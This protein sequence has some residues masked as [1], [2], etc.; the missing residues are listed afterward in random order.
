[1]TTNILP[2][3][4]EGWT[5]HHPNTDGSL[6]CLTDHPVYATKE[7]AEA[8]QARYHATREAGQSALMTAYTKPRGSIARSGPGL[9]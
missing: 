5:L 2:D 9:R 4:A 7:A 3:A 6:A 1:M 8:A